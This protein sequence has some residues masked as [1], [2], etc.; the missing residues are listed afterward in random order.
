M[1]RIAPQLGF[2]REALR[3][4][5]R[6]DA[7]DLE[8]GAVAYA[9]DQA[10]LDRFFT[11]LSCG[12]VYN[13]CA[14]QL[15]SNYGVGHVYHNLHTEGLSTEEAMLHAELLDFYRDDREEDLLGV[16]N[17]GQA[18]TLNETVYSARIFGLPDFRSSIT[19]VHRFFGTFRVTSMLTNRMAIPSNAQD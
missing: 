16:L 5:L 18:E 14:K 4:T 17:F 7:I 6:K 3:A 11:A 19:V 1:S 15:P 9:V 12:I 8:N 2:N 10:R 13:A